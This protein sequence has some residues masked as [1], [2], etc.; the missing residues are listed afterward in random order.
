MFNPTH[1][2]LTGR[3]DCPRSVK[4]LAAEAVEARRLRDAQNLRLTAHNAA[5]GMPS[6]PDARPDTENDADLTD[7]SAD[8]QPPQDA[9]ADTDADTDAAAD[10]AADAAAGFLGEQAPDAR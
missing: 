1:T 3:Q 9:D 4:F 5:Q 2:A 6:S 7:L 10:S 8:E